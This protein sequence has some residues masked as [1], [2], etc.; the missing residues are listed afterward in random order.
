MTK[1]TPGARKT[2]SGTVVK[3]ATEPGWT[4]LELL[5]S[6]VKRTGSSLIRRID[7]WQA[8]RQSVVTSA[9]DVLAQ[10]VAKASFG[11]VQEGANE[12]KKLGVGDHPLVARLKLE[13]NPHQ[14]WMGFWMQVIP[15]LALHQEAF[16]YQRRRTM[17]DMD[18]DLVAIHPDWVNQN[19]MPWGYIY[20][21]AAESTGAEVMLGFLSARLTDADLIHIVGR[22][23]NGF[24]GLSTIAVGQDVLGLNAMMVDFQA[25]I[26]KAGV[27]PTGLIQVPELMDDK[28]FERLKSQILKAL[29]AAVS[30]GEPLILEQNASW[31]DL[32]ANAEQADLVKARQ[33]L[34]QEVARLFRM[35]PHKV[36][37]LDSVKYENLDTM[38]KNYVDDT[39]V[40]VCELIEQAMSKALLSVPDRLKGITF[41]FDREE[42]YDRD[43][44]ARRERIEKQF[45]AGLL[46]L[47]EARAM[48][49]KPPV[50]GH[51][52]HRVLP[53]NSVMIFRDGRVQTLAGQKP[54]PTSEQP[55]PAPSK[56]LDPAMLL[57]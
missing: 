31:K 11:L 3:T 26:A 2:I 5:T 32:G 9:L 49:G 1:S 46:W 6:M 47:N 30:T 39:V 40:P 43:P 36:G 56:G 12:V 50:E 54:D 48:L 55:V 28:A 35:P 14:T 8:M 7:E 27:K 21:C 41:R 24:E 42:L 37:L 15:Q 25:A 13:P 17:A 19:A 38:E 52:D 22:S 16:I 53:A 51:L 29:N 57:N 45:G 44:A 10:D 33:L 34:A 18:P 4:Q 23:R 20:D